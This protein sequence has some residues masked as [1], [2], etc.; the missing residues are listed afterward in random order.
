MD[1]NT[2]DFFNINTCSPLKSNSFGD[3]D[4]YIELSKESIKES[5]DSSTPPPKNKFV[6]YTSI[7]HQIEESKN[8]INNE[9]SKILEEKSING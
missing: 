2:S 5:S 9:L 7:F 1:S 4:E 6:D 3:Y 8:N